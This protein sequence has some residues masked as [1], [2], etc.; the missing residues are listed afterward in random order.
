MQRLLSVI[1]FLKANDLEGFYERNTVASV[2]RR[3][4]RH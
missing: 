4:A 1:T 3:I 2:E